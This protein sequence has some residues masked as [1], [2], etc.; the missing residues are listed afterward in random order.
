MQLNTLHYV[1]RVCLMLAYLLMIRVHADGFSW[2][3]GCSC[4]I[5][6]PILKAD[7]AYFTT[8]HI[9][10]SVE[11]STFAGCQQCLPST[12]VSLRC[13]YISVMHTHLMYCHDMYRHIFWIL[14]SF[15]AERRLTPFYA[16]ILKLTWQ[17]LNMIWGL[18]TCVACL[19]TLNIQIHTA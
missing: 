3:V 7:L 19:S 11:V 1:R 17:C 5:Y 14:F 12:T 2:F 8:H 16:G 10:C 6:I 13:D 9:L 4:V 18:I 15:V